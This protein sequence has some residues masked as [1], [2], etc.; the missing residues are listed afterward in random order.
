[1]VKTLKISDDAHEKLTALLG[2][3]TAQTRT[4][5]TYADAIEALLNRSVILPTQ[6]LEEVEKTIKEHPELGY[7]TKE[8]FIRDAIRRRIDSVTEIVEWI[9]I[10]REKYEKAAEAIKEMNVARTVD[11][12]VEDQL[13]RLIEEYEKYREYQEQ[14]EEW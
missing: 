6:L 1:M 10:D 4:M 3:L 11:E 14:Q 9:G 8:E 12:F 7:T 13:D 5:Q 2:E